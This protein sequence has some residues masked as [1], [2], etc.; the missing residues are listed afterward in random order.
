LQ[1]LGTDYLD[2]Y[3]CHRA[4]PATPLLETARAMDDLIRQGK[5]LY[6]GTSEWSAAQLAEVTE[7]CERYNLHRPQSE[8][9]QYSMLYRERVEAEILPVTDPRGIGLV[10]WSPLGMGMLTGK[11]DDG[12]PNDSRFSREPW[13]KERYLT[14]VNSERVRRLKP[15][16]DELGINRSQLALA[17]VLRHTGV[18]SVITGAT[19]TTQVE[20]NAKAADVEL[21]PDVVAAIED[22]LTWTP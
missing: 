5:V 18:S 9:P 7:L 11:Y 14:D 19:K 3:F 20:D 4:D 21:T 13:A 1:R 16:A 22:V 10:I 8:Q 6:W 15:I 2:I 12:V 17:W